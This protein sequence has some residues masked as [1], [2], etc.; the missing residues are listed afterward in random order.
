MV[1]SVNEDTGETRG[2]EY[3]RY[4][5]ANKGIA[6]RVVVPDFKMKNPGNPTQEELDAYAAALDRKYG[7]FSLNNDK[8]YCSELVWVIYKEQLGVELCKLNPLQHYRTFG[9]KSLLKKRGISKKSLFVAPSDLI[10]SRK[11]YSV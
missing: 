7:Q 9:L 1:I 5:P 4:D 8:Y 11:L 3:G 2:S 6:R 10:K